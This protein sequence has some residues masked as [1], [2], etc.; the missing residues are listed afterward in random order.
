MLLNTLASV[1]IPNVMNILQSKKKIELQCINKLTPTIKSPLVWQGSGAKFKWT[2]TT[3]LTTP[4]TA[5]SHR[6]HPYNICS[7]VVVCV[8]FEG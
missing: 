8:F 6:T 1:F 5:P 7:S 3:V 4:G 2:L